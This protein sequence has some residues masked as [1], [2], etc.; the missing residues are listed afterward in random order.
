[1]R[2]DTFE[3]T[4]EIYNFFFSNKKTGTREQFADMVR[5]CNAVGVRIYPDVII[6]H[7]SATSG[8]FY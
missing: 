5:R 8:W 4:F 3:F 7:M 2:I 1:L 6:N